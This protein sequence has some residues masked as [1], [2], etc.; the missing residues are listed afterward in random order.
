[1]H[2]LYAL[3]AVLLLAMPA[4]AA[5]MLVTLYLDGARVDIE[6][7]VLKEFAEVSLPSAIH[8]GS[9]RIKPLDGCRIERVEIV[10]VK[11]DP[12]ILRDVSKMTARRD[13]L[14]DRLKAL[15]ARETIFL[16]AA[17][18]QSAKAP[19]KSKT[20]PEPLTAV[21]QGTEFAI[22]RLEEVYR[23]RRIAENELKSL[24]ARLAE[25]K[26]DA[27]GNVA[28]VKLSRKG[29]RMAVSYFRSDLV[30]HPAYDFRLNRSGEAD[31]VMRAVLPKLAMGARVSV[32]PALLA[33]AVNEKALP[34]NSQN[35]PPVATFILPLIQEKFSSTPV[36]SIS[37][38]FKNI[39]AIKLPAGEAYGF[40][41][42]EYLGKVDF[43]GA[44]PGEEREL[45]FGM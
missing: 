28:R 10:P 21:R 2:L 12:G 41:K 11:S 45:N 32:V 26:K 13:A 42:G 25:M 31:V 29:G 34:V 37:F 36:S 40:V 16:A 43:R 23:A 6:T 1:M 3:I 19:R 18:S 8:D 27:G 5:N 35:F 15:D 17:K 20:N 14:S 7:G 30:W 39:S 33:D 4:A 22:A 38:R 44:L 9:L 24:D